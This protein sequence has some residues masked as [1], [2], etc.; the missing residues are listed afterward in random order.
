MAHS[1]ATPVRGDRMG[2]GNQA[3]QEQI[4][5]RQT[6]AH[7][8]QAMSPESL[9]DTGLRGGVFS[10]AMA[11]F[12]KAYQEGRSTSPVV[13]IIDYEL[14]S[15]QKRLWVIDLAQK[16]LLFHEFTTHGRGSDRNHDGKMDSASNTV[17]S[18]QSNVGLL[19]TD[20]PYTG[21]H[22]K[23][24]RMDGLEPGFNDNAKDRAIVFHSARYADDEYIARHGKAGRSHGCP[25]LDPDVSG[26]IID[27]IKDGKLVFAY[28]PDQ[29]WLEQ[30]TYL[31][32]SS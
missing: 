26:R 20:Q 4:R 6:A 27:T 21:R 32:E 17:N 15:N 8:A 14:P 10:K 2:H 12:K 9:T 11:S 25:A 24:L 22:G 29:N 3:V 13:T 23:S 19:V 7:Y 18:N 5:Q 1:P 31:N 30:S 16:K 28:Y